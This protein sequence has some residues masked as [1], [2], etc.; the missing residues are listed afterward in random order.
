MVE[1]K[2]TTKK[3]ET[4]DSEKIR[5]KE[6]EEKMEKKKL[7]KT[8][9]KSTEKKETEKEKKKE[10]ENVPKDKAIARGVSLRISPKFS[11]AIC[12]MIKRKS[13]EK[14]VEMLEEVILLKRP[15]KMNGLEV[16]HQKGKGVAGARFPK[17]ASIEILKVVK[18]LN[19]NASVAGIEDPVIK[20]AKADKAARPY[21]KEGRRAK[22]THLYLEAVSLAKLKKK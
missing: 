13:P 6:T 17:N 21:K 8:E 20:I 14:A 19:A 9:E 5:E 12:K 15:V 1:K 16:A 3:V 18:Q 4:K 2:K 7:E 11:F 10:K 22:R